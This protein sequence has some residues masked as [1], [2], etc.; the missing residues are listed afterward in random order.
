MTDDRIEQQ[1]AELAE[2]RK[3]KAKV[4]RLRHH[5]DNG[6][7]VFDEQGRWAGYAGDLLDW[8]REATG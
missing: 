8:L 6:T 4:D 7:Y 2:L 5:P 1:E 3:L